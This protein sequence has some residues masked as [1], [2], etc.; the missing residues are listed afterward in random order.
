MSVDVSEKNFEATIEPALTR[1]PLA[2]V[3]ES[4]G[5]ASTISESAGGGFL[6]GGYHRRTSEAYDRGLCII[7]QDVRERMD[8]PGGAG[9]HSAQEP[10]NPDP[11]AVLAPSRRDAERWVG[12]EFHPEGGG[13][14]CLPIQRS[15]RRGVLARVQL[16][17]AG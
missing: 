1:D 6:S 7:P 9:C 16:P 2:L 3:P 15:L 14:A 4:T 11:E 8:S 13:L 10:G 17:F 12:S 5:E